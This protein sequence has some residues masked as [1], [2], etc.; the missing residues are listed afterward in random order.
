MAAA[1]LQT[2]CDTVLVEIPQRFHFDRAAAVGFCHEVAQAGVPVLVIQDLDWIGP[3]LEISLI[4][5]M[6]ETLESF[7]CLKVEVRPAGPKY[8]QVREATQG[9]LS[10]AGGWAADQ[11]IEALDR[12]VDIFMPTAMTGHYAE[13]IRDHRAG[14]REASFP[15]FRAILP[16]LAFTRQHLDISIQF[17]KRLMVHRGIFKTAH[18]QEVPAVRQLSR[19]IRRRDDALSRSA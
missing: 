18:P 17:Y 15:K 2:G 14:D 16:V 13:I 8:T 9:K 3:G 19:E 4:V 1:A 6:F 12:G 5:E 10:I 11:M 7:K